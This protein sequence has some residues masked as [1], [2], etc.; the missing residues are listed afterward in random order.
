MNL[1]E[2]TQNRRNW[3]S[4]IPTLMESSPR[5]NSSIV[6]NRILRTLY[7]WNNPTLPVSRIVPGEHCLCPLGK[8]LPKNSGLSKTLRERILGSQFLTR[9]H[10][11][12]RPEGSPFDN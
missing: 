5:G 10:I 3:P 6:G 11:R 8:R 1:D 4:R 7:P 9:G 12:H 2:I